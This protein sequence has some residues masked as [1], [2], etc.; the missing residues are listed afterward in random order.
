LVKIFFEVNDRNGPGKDV[1]IQRILEHPALL[2][3][4]L[5]GGSEPIQFTGNRGIHGS[6]IIKV[7]LWDGARHID[8]FVRRQVVNRVMKP[9]GIYGSADKAEGGQCQ[10]VSPV[11]F[12][13]PFGMTL[14]FLE[15]FHIPRD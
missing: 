4:L 9:S 15:V 5:Y 13:D 7:S 8:P 10:L 1:T 12:V 14:P 11:A 6:D 2:P 3:S